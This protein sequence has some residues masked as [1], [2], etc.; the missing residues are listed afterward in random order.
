M[1]RT[2]KGLRLIIANINLG[3][4]L[5]CSCNGVG[6]NSLSAGGFSG[7]AIGSARTRTVIFALRNLGRRQANEIL[8]T[9]KAAYVTDICVRTAVLIALCQLPL[10]NAASLEVKSSPAR[11]IAPVVT[12]VHCQSPARMATHATMG[13]PA[14]W[15]SADHCCIHPTVVAIVR[16]SGA[17]R[18]AVEKV[19]PG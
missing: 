7:V 16:S 11:H 5:C 10:D 6:Q 1:P 2:R 9:R 4:G 19:L 15:P 14:N 8:E 12:Q 17:T 13:G 18:S 3:W